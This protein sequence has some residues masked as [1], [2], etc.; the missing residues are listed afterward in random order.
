MWGKESQSRRVICWWLF[1]QCW[2][3]ITCPILIE[4]EIERAFGNGG[5]THRGLRSQSKLSRFT[6]LASAGPGQSPLDTHSAWPCCVQDL[7]LCLLSSQRWGCKALGKPCHG[8]ASSQSLT[9]K[10]WIQKA[11]VAMCWISIKNNTWTMYVLQKCQHECTGQH[12]QGHPLQR[13][14]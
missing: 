11:W 6:L 3:K 9:N 2:N 4:M 1:I 12:T 10:H 5:G 7:N 14:S 8:K 13:W